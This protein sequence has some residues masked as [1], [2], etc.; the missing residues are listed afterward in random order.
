MTGF[1]YELLVIMNGNRR[2]QCLYCFTATG[3]L[4]VINVSVIACFL[5]FFTLIVYFYVCLTQQF[6][7][8]KA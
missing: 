2:R 8:I 4:N 1:S 6:P 5:K 7:S 3:V